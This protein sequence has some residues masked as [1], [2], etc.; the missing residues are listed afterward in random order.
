MFF[1]VFRQAIFLFHLMHSKNGRVEQYKSMSS[2]ASASQSVSEII[3]EAFSSL[4]AYIS[5][6]F[7]YVG[8]GGVDD[9]AYTADSK[10]NTPMIRV[11]KRRN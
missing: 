1:D 6:Q 3:S 7:V 4:H 5:K 11:R 9:E 2:E 8:W 10:V